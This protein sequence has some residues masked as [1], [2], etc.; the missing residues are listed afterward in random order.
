MNKNPLLA[1][2]ADIK[3]LDRVSWW[4]LGP[5]W[6]V[7]IGIVCVFMIAVVFLKLRRD[8]YRRSWRGEAN[9]ALDGLRGRPGTRD[10]VGEFS[11]LLRRIAIQKFSRP[12]AAGLE[13]AAWLEWLKA[14]DPRGFDWTERGRILTSAPYAPPGAPVDEPDFHVLID[15]AKGWLA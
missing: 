13:G 7:V 10:A 12:Q 11:I 4:P 2:M 9:A 5:G 6:W 3:G 15:A 1:Q 8:A 14:N